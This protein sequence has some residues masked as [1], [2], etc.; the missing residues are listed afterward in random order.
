MVSKLGLM[1]VTVVGL[2]GQINLRAQQSNSVYGTLLTNSGVATSANVLNVGQVSHLVAVHYSNAPAQTCVAPTPT[3]T[4]EY[5]F[6][7]STFIPFGQTININDSQIDQTYVGN[8]LY[9]YVRFKLTAI[10][11]NCLA[12]AYYT[13]TLSGIQQ[14]TTNCNAFKQTTIAAASPTGTIVANSDT[15]TSI[16]VCGI[17]LSETSTT[18][19]LVQVYQSLSGNSCV[20]VSSPTL[21]GPVVLT[22]TNPN[23]VMGSG[24][25]LLFNLRNASDL[26]WVSTGLSGGTS[27]YITVSYVIQ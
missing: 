8:G 3:A 23:L 19:A 21:L 16:R 1:L 18:N 10:N 25:G 22:P 11:S 14:T 13:G 17:T 9:P 26:C 27:A 2:M 24:A 15:T 4:L 7:N 20:G 12:T 5:S 6:N